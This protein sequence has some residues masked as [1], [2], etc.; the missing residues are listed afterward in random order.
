MSPTSPTPVL[1]PR[2]VFAHSL[3]ILRADGF[4]FL[5]L[6]VVAG[7]PLFALHLDLAGDR[8]GVEAAAAAFRFPIHRA[9]PVDVLEAWTGTSTF[10]ALLGTL[11]PL[12]LQGAVACGVFLSLVGLPVSLRASVAQGAK[13]ALPVLGAAILV[14][15]F[16]AV[17]PRMVG[18]LT[19]AV[20][21]AL[22]F[23]LGP[24]AFFLVATCQI[25]LYV[26]VPAVTVEK[27]TGPVRALVRSQALTRGSG[28]AI[29]RIWFVLFGMWAIVHVGL[30]SWGGFERA[31]TLLATRGVLLVHDLALA[32]LA[33]FQAVTA[34]VVYTT[35][36][37][38]KEGVGDQEIARVFD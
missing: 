34:A 31:G 18:A 33:V 32:L 23:L 1:E 3:R 35:L 21:P 5:L 13:R 19:R 22:T 16:V 4:S 24:A 6:A 14:F 26:V 20:H 28:R 38:A 27:R 2:K 10:Q 8:V 7:L 29:F 17:G 9:R 11:L 15:L 30:I 25:L 36:W 12:V 37:T